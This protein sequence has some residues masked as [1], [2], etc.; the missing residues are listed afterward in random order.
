[1]AFAP[2]TNQLLMNSP[3]LDSSN[4]NLAARQL[5]RD[6]SSAISS[7]PG[8]PLGNNNLPEANLARDFR[9]AKTDSLGRPGSASSL[10]SDLGRPV[11]DNNQ[12]PRT[13]NNL[14]QAKRSA[15]RRPGTSDAN[16]SLAPEG[17]EDSAKNLINNLTSSLLRKS[18]WNIIDT[19]GLTF[20]YVDFHILGRFVF[21][22]EMFCKLGQEWDPSKALG[23]KEMGVVTK[24]SKSVSSGGSSS[25]SFFGI[26]Y[27]AIGIPETGLV[28]S[29]NA[30]IIVSIFIALV[31]IVVIGMILTDSSMAL[32]FLGT[33]WSITRGV[34]GLSITSLTNTA[35]LVSSAIGL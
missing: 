19:W 30:L 23:G 9:Q 1:M 25:S 29:V 20:L 3:R 16:L 26:P 22:P 12:G 18:W 32:Q 7:R 34:F 33:F 35:K 31:P 24:T 13:S 14:R 4:E 5:R 10:S 11:G 17:A 27:S 15:L 21:G 8:S 6:R 28:G 2:A